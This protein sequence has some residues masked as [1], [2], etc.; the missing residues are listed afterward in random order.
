MR[1]MLLLYGE[2]TPPEAVTPEIWEHVVKSHTEFTRRL[3]EAGAYV[4][5][6]PLEPVENAKTVR[7]RRHERLVT[8]GPFAETREVLGGYYLIEAGSLDDAVAW[9]EQ[10]DSMSD[11]SIE[12]RPIWQIDVDSPPPRSS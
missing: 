11:G 7:L 5:S 1:Y 9:A 4:D 6:A 8:D 12:V 10:L 3:K 2:P